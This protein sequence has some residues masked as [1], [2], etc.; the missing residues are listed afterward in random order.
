MP[1]GYPIP[2]AADLAWLSLVPTSAPAL[3]ADERGRI[4]AISRQAT[5]PRVIARCTALPAT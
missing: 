1:A 3:T 5:D 2:S 4:A